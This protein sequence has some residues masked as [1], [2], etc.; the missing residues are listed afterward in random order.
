MKFK[1]SCLQQLKISYTHRTIVSIYIIYK[2]GASGSHDND[3]TL[4]NYLVQLL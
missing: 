2:L 1:G 4:K 3:P